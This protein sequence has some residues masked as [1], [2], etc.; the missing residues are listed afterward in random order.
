MENNDGELT[1]EQLEDVAGGAVTLGVTLVAITAVTIGPGIGFRIAS[2]IRPYPTQTLGHYSATYESP[3]HHRGFLFLQSPSNSPK[4]TLTTG[5]IF[6]LRC[7]S[8][9]SLHA[10]MSLK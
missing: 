4:R 8:S 10:K 1:D 6:L 2:L 7:Q 9:G 5:T 3:C